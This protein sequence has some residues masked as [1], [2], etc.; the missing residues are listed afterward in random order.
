MR[1]LH[2]GKFFPPHPGGIERCMAD[3]CTALTARGVAVAALAHAEPGAKS[4]Q[5]RDPAGFDVSLAACHGQLLYAPLSP[6]FPFLLKR[7]LAD[8]RPDL[9]HLHHFAGFVGFLRPA[10]AGRAPSAVGRPLARRHSA[11]HAPPHAAAGIR[12]LPPLGT[13]DAAA[14]ECDHRHVA[15][16]SRFECR[17][18]TLAKQTQH[19]HSTWHRWSSPLP[20]CRRGER[21]PLE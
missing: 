3:M 20:R 7:T 10:V 18:R 4:I 14:R 21:A 13:R 17:A 9:L 6:S 8:F 11:R 12:D 15:A 2:V 1:V 5:R 16:V 19:C